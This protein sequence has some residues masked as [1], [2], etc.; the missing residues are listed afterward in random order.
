MREGGCGSGAE[1]GGKEGWEVVR[2]GARGCGCGL[3]CSLLAASCLLGGRRGRLR[4]TG[5]RRSVA[6]AGPA[7]RSCFAHS[8]VRLGAGRMR[9]TEYGTAGAVTA[10]GGGRPCQVGR[11]AHDHGLPYQQGRRPYD[12]VRVPAAVPGGQYGKGGHAE[13]AVQPLQYGVRALGAARK[14]QGGSG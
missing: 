2:A 1:S 13:D 14:E 7:V 5:A 9:R 3:S 10:A 11:N 4:C 8:C 6:Y 12:Q